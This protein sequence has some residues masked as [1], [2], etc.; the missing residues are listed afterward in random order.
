MSPKKS[1]LA[2]D[3]TA[4]VR[5]RAAKPLGDKQASPVDSSGQRAP[6]RLRARLDDDE[7]GAAILDGILRGGVDSTEDAPSSKIPPAFTHGEAKRHTQRTRK[8]G[9]DLADCLRVGRARRVWEPMGL[10]SFEAWV[11]EVF[12]KKRSRAYQLLRNADDNEQLAEAGSTIVDLKEA[13]TRALHAAGSFNALVERLTQLH[14]EGATDARKGEEIEAAVTSA[15]S[16]LKTK[17]PTES[18]KAATAPATGAKEPRESEDVTI[19]ESIYDLVGALED[20]MIGAP[21]D[22]ETEERQ[23]LRVAAKDLR[24]TVREL[25]AW[26]DAAEEGAA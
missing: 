6:K 23:G 17:R 22:L 13:D 5:R 24:A 11:R 18:S 4:P 9:R 3:R 7:P 1:A 25:L 21:S 2:T 16:L 8:A 15:K 14:A 20:L 12:G 19:G 10:P 26:L